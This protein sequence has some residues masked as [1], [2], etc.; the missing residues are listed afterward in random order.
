MR[1]PCLLRGQLVRDSCG[2]SLQLG[3]DPINEYIPTRTTSIMRTLSSV[4]QGHTRPMTADGSSESNG[5]GKHTLAARRNANKLVQ[6]GYRIY[7]PVTFT[8]LHAL[9]DHRPQPV[10]AYVTMGGK[11]GQ[12]QMTI[13]PFP[14]LANGG[15]YVI[16]FGPGDEQPGVGK[17]AK[18]LVVYDAF[19]F[20]AQGNV[21]LQ[22][23][24]SPNE[25]VR[26]SRSQ[27]SSCH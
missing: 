6:Q 18:W 19:D 26:D 16:V 1:S 8:T 2:R 7:T 13:D 4:R 9:V 20:D 14:Q 25:P 11:V 10:A 22:Q 3:R 12:D 21:I 27:R 24:G 17:V 5:A 15:H 23:A